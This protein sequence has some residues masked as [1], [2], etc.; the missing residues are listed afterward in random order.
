VFWVVAFKGEGHTIGRRIV[1]GRAAAIAAAASMLDLGIEVVS[2]K[3][4]TE[5]EFVSEDEVRVVRELRHVP[6]FVSLRMMRSRDQ[7]RLEASNRV[8][9]R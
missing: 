3:G 7:V 6:H 9:S 5:R 1:F 8:H 2:V 4:E